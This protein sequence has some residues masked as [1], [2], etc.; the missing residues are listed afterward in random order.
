MPKLAHDLSWTT[1]IHSNF[2]LNQKITMD[3]TRK[4]TGFNLSRSWKPLLHKLRE[5]RHPPITPQ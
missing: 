1:G 5:R 2:D 3:C 4:P